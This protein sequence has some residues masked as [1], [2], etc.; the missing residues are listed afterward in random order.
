MKN[1][2]PSKKVGQILSSLKPS[3]L[4]KGVDILNQLNKSGQADALKKQFE[5]V[6]QSKIMEMFN[7]LDPN[8]IKNKLNDMDL[9]NLDLNK[10]ANGS[11][12]IGINKK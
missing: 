11:K 5:G 2:D 3:Q 9:N 1:N 7:K 4:K 6:D 10:Y 12:K 8:D